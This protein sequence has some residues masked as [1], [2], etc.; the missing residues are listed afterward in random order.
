M[1]E[2]E[3]YA[4]NIKPMSEG[5]QFWDLE[6]D[7]SISNSTIQV[8]LNSEGKLPDNYEL[9]ILDRD[10]R[11]IL[12]VAD[13]TF[14]ID[15]G[16]NGSARKLRV[17]LGS[18]QFI[19]QHREDIPLVPLEFRLE[20]NFP[21]PF[22]GATTIRYEISEESPVQLEVFNLMGQRVLLMVDGVQEAGSYELQWDGNNENGLP[23]ASGIYLYRIRAGEFTDVRKMLL[24]R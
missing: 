2:G 14:T 16:A 13:S 21:N 4:R 24:V 3:R 20:Q 22:N 17:L 12:D 5:G 18:E 19:E 9:F 23:F 7:A 11:K 6:I 1:E 8:T 15:L 10:K